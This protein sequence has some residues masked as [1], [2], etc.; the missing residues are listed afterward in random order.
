MQEKKS[1]KINSILNILKTLSS[2]LFPLI[3]FPYISRVLQPEYVGKV[4]FGASYINYFSLIA[5]LGI[6]TYAIRECSAVR[7]DK[8]KLERVASEI[9]SINVCTTGIAYILLFASLIL[10]RRLDS[11]RTL[12]IIQSTVILFT[13]WGQ[14][15]LTQR[16]KIL[17]T[18]LLEPLY[19]NLF[20]WS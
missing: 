14:S 9:F 15:G 12:I 18:L 20:P 11:Y 5:S 1:I 16:W 10:F 8:L 17:S 2:I 3:T 6:T 4:N 13:T 7:K 19:F